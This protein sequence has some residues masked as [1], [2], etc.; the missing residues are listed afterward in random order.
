MHL[1]YMSALMLKA[2]TVLAKQEA[3]YDGVEV[4][5][6]IASGIDAARY[7]ARILGLLRAEHIVVKNCWLTM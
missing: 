3:Q 7:S 5:S 4:C 1:F 6:A 2:R